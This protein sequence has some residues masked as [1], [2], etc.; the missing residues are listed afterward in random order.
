MTMKRI[1]VFLL[2]VPLFL[3]WACQQ[4][5]NNSIATTPGEWPV[6]THLQKPWTRW[7][8]MG[9]AVDRQNITKNLELMASAGIGGVEITPIYGVKGYEDRF[10]DFLSPAY[11]EL[12]KYTVDEA[13]RLGMQ[14]D[15]VLGTGWPYGGPQVEP[16]YAASRLMIQKY[17]LAA[18]DALSEPIQIN[19]KKQV[20]LARLISVMAFDSLERHNELVGLVD[21]AGVLNWTPDEGIATLYAIFV[22]KTRQ[23]VKRAAPG[24]AGYTLDHFSSAAFNDYVEP[25]DTALK[26]IKLR[27]IF[28]D[29]YEVYGADFTPDFFERFKEYRG[30]DL[31]PLI[32]QFVD[33]D[34]LTKSQ[35]LADYRETIG[36]LLLEEFSASWKKW[37]NKNRYL[38]KYQA[39]GSPGNL[40]DLYASADIPECETF[41]STLFEIPGLRRDSSDIRHVDPDPVMLKFSSSAAHIAGHPLVS[42]ESFTWL[43]DH[44]KVSLSQCKPELEQLFLSGVNHVFFHGSTYSP[45]EAEW[46][47]WKFYASVNFNYNNTIWKDAPAFF[48]Y[49][50]RCQSILQYGQ[51]DNELLVYWPYYDA[52]TTASPGKMFHQFG[53]HSIKEWL[54]PTPFY[55]DLQELKT[56]GYSF[57]F[58]SDQFI[59]EASFKNGMIIMPGGSYKALVVPACER[60]LPETLG[61]LESLRKRGANIIFEGLPCTAPGYHDLEKREK[62]INASASRIL[63]TG[64]GSGSVVEKLVASGLSGESFAQSKLQFIRRKGQLG[65]IYFIANHSARSVND[66]IPLKAGGSTVVLLD[67]MT[68]KRG[69]AKVKTEEDRSAVLLQLEPGETI[70]VELT[71]Q[72]VDLP[73]WEYIGTQLPEIALEGIWRVEFLE[74]GPVIPDPF[75]IETI[76]PWQTW[77]KATEAFSGTA[78]YSLPFELPETGSDEYVLDLGLVRESARVKINGHDAGTAWAIP[79]KLRIGKWLKSGENHIEI[80]VTNLAANRIR[81]LEKSG[82]E[83]KIFYEINMVDVGYRTFDATKWEPT[84]SGL[85]QA[86]R[87]IPVN[88]LE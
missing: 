39:H 10:I 19:D 55:H 87:L 88:Y 65:T 46:P 36:D 31:K 1:V 86:P 47:G 83:W 38:T 71:D 41:G 59:S 66:Y 40:I 54:H 84:P 49:I 28:N 21:T 77:S 9:N 26:N 82:K 68:G 56:N 78:R 73:E 75:V 4:K 3:N 61:K 45:F 62:A 22:G 16:E 13:E 11:I 17:T 57:D 32:N 12:L 81:A 85:T 63:T 20:G 25:Y 43:A 72:N 14:V 15:M 58:V 48:N 60:M 52:L 27:A 6:V 76:T 44:F 34:S 53:V 5:F 74:G 8:W 50:S 23:M 70:F 51:P 67:P 33:G 7:W 18:G 80:E 24:G 35:L 64:I 29:S 37:S 42:S 30:Y 2:L 79:F 69:K